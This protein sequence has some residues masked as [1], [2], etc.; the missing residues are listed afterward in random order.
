[1]N[2]PV[3]HE[4]DWQTMLKIVEPLADSA[5]EMVDLGRDLAADHTE[6][7]LTQEFQTPTCVFAQS[8]FPHPADGMK[9][10]FALKRF[11]PL[12]D[13]IISSQPQVWEALH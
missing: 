8:G 11:A 1:M 7:M 12:H 4:T 6:D 9:P 2:S 3:T 5:I 13:D 10:R